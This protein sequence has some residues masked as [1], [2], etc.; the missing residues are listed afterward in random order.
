[1]STDHQVRDEALE[2]IHHSMS[3]IPPP[4][5]PGDSGEVPPRAIRVTERNADFG[6]CS[7][8]VSCFRIGVW[9]KRCRSLNGILFGIHSRKECQSFMWW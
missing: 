3:R 8:F 5:T 9:T 2:S 6:D 7:V 4:G 1:M